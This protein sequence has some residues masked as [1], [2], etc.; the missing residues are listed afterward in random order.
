[1]FTEI[2]EQKFVYISFKTAIE[3]AKQ[4]LAAFVVMTYCHSKGFIVAVALFDRHTSH[5]YFY[6]FFFC[7][8]KVVQL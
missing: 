3:T 4:P 1:M 7:L 8:T 5:K 2:T 6:L